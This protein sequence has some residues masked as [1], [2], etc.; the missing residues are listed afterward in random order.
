MQQELYF[1]F[2][3]PLDLRKCFESGVAV[4]ESFHVPLSMTQSVINE[5]A[6]PELARHVVG[7]ALENSIAPHG[8]AVG[9]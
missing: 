8:V 9:P 1:E 6:G 4:R 5:F 2:A 7:F 3:L